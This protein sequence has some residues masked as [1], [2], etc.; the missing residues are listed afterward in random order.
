MPSN[1]STVPSLSTQ[2]RSSREI[3]IFSEAPAT[4]LNVN[5]SDEGRATPKLGS[6]LRVSLMTRTMEVMPP[7][8]NRMGKVLI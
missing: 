2:A 6:P 1:S 4:L 5:K 7:F 8:G 3:S